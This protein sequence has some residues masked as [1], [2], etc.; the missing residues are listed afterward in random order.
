MQTNNKTIGTTERTLPLLIPTPQR[1]SSIL[2]LGQPVGGMDRDRAITHSPLAWSCSPFSSVHRVPWDPLRFMPA[3]GYRIVVS[4]AKLAANT[5]TILLLPAM[6]LNN[7]PIINVIDWCEVVYSKNEDIK[8]VREMLCFC[9]PPCQFFF[10]AVMLVA[11]P[12]SL[13]IGA[14]PHKPMRRR[15]R[16]RLAHGALVHRC[17][18]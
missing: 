6:A 9:P 8:R 13:C 2:T 3:S 1:R 10:P 12:L 11:A 16:R 15:R 18:I 5:N 4:G 14:F 7:Q 17:R